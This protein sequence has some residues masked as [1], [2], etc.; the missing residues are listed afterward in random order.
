[1]ANLN[2]NTYSADELMK[3][4]VVFTVCLGIVVILFLVCVF[5]VLN[6]TLAIDFI[7]SF[8]IEKGAGIGAIL[9][10]FYFV[11]RLVFKKENKNGK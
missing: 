11:L 5:C 6:P 7:G 8:S 1:M 9:L 10:F 4:A 3:L 2:I